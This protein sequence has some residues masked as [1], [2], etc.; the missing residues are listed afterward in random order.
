MDMLT[1]PLQ[2]P[3]LTRELS[4]PAT[5]PAV[6][7]MDIKPPQVEIPIA[8][9]VHEAPPEEDEIDPKSGKKTKEAKQ[10]KPEKIKKPHQPGVGGAIFASVV[11]VL[12]LSALAVYAYLKTNNIAVF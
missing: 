2:Q 10:P 3:D 8:N 5:K 1:K 11:I 4:P 12:A 9:E 6:P 7:V